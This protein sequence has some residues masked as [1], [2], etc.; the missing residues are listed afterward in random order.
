MKT[1]FILASNNQNKLR[2]IRAILSEYGYD[3]VPQ[4]EAGIHFEVEETGTTFEENAILKATYAAKALGLPAIADDT[5][6]MVDA[7]D[8]RPGI[9]SS[10]Y[11]KTDEERMSKLLK[12]LA[13]IPPEKR[14]AKFVSAVAIVLPNGETH[15]VRGEIHGIIAEKPHGSGGFGYDKLFI[16]PEYNQTFGELPQDVKNKISHRAKSLEKLKKLIGEMNYADK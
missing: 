3:I 1:K 6:L 15:T 13:G 4:S 9:Y 10:R 11:A 7:L 5:G 8:G 12:E 2:E 16:V 14:T